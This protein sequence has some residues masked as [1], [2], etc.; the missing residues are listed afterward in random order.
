MPK[1]SESI[2]PILNKKYLMILTAFIVTAVIL[3]KGFEGS[4]LLIT[5]IVLAILA[6][7]TLLLYTNFYWQKINKRLRPYIV[8]RI[9]Q[10]L[11]IIT[12]VVLFLGTFSMAQENSAWV[13]YGGL[14]LLGIYVVYEWTAIF[15]VAKAA[16]KKDPNTCEFC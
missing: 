15:M 1:K 4:L 8:A 2:L 12:V 10:T 16:K 14:W 11:S 13:S 5:Y 7:P 3:P 6:I 9:V